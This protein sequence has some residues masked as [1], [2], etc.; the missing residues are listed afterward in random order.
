MFELR[1]VGVLGGDTDTNLSCYLLGRPGQAPLVQLDSGTV[2]SGLIKVQ[3]RSGILKPEATMSQ[4]E[5]AAL[6]LLSSLQAVLVTHSHLDHAGGL[7]QEGGMMASLTTKGHAPLEIVTMPTT[8][9]VLAE[10]LFG[11]PLWIDFTREPKDHPAFKLSPLEPMS[12]RSIGPFEVQAIPL[13]HT[14]E[15]AAFLV[16][17]GPDAYLHLGDTSASDEV[18]KAASPFFTSH[19]LRAITVEVSWPASDEKKAEST[20]H[21]TRNS[22]L[23]ELTKLS[24]VPIKSAMPTADVM[25][26][27]IALEVARQ[28]APAFKDCPI[29]A[30][31]IKAM[32][33]DQ[34]LKEMK[35][36][37][38]AGLNIIVP[39]QGETYRF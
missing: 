4:Q 15:S 2:I 12:H 20:G 32:K 26:D 34:V 8:A 28:L 35:A 7:A 6:D 31:H 14:V 5:Q 37:Q 9:K 11:S 13:H 19:H 33:Y 16:T 25:S 27:E 17:L 21:L 10:S 18:W 1:A 36:L 39:E 3:Q 24:P 23:L 30:T 38:A 22:M 29:I